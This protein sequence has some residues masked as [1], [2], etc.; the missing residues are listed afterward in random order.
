MTRCAV[1]ELDYLGDHETG[2]SIRAEASVRE[3]RKVW[4]SA[5]TARDGVRAKVVSVSTCIMTQCSPKKFFKEYWGRDRGERI[6]A[7]YE[8]K[9]TR[10]KKEKDC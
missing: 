3:A 8:T 9:G 6:G 10:K 5:R 7:N 2:N 1:C 4:C